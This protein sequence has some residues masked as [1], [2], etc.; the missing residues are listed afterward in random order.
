V[1]DWPFGQDIMDDFI[2][3]D[4]IEDMA[5][6]GEA[7]AANA[8]DA[9]EAANARANKD[10]RRRFK[11]EPPKEWMLLWAGFFTGPA[12][13]LN[14]GLRLEC[15]EAFRELGQPNGKGKLP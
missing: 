10:E 6:A 15:S 4:F 5:G 9:S 7:A 1:Y 8:G 11:T 3:E 12:R 14:E 2:E 13:T